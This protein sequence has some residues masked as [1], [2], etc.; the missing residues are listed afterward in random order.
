M[1]LVNRVCKPYLDK[2]VIVSIDGI[3]IY[4]K[5]KEEHGVH[6]KLVLESVVTEEGEVDWLVITDVHREFFKIV[7]PLTSPTERNQKKKRVK[8]RRVRGMILAPL[9]EAFKQENVLAERLHSLDQQME[10]KGDESL[11]FMNRI[12]VL[13]VT[14]QKVLETRLDLSDASI[15]KRVACSMGI[16]WENSLT[17]LESVQ[18]TIDKVVLVKEKPK[19]ARD[20]QKSYVD[21]R[22]KP[23]EFEVGDHVL[24][25]VTP[26][27]EVVRKRYLL[28][29]LKITFHFTFHFLYLESLL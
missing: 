3:L 22:R 16:D 18:E 27:K 2:F 20:C 24:L 21:Y 5:T 1:D 6:L 15:L 25:K 7:E 13:F 29:F 8:S 14:V 17:G 12:W 19:A 9:S 26:W 11:Y 23:L 10:R 4:S 28:N